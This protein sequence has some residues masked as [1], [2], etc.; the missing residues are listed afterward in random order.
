MF[1][2]K[3]GVQLHIESFAYGPYPCPQKA[4][5][6]ARSTLPGGESTGPLPGASGSSLAP[7]VHSGPATAVNMEAELIPDADPAA[8][9]VRSLYRHKSCFYLLIYFSRWKW[10][11]WRQVSRGWRGCPAWEVRSTALSWA[12]LNG[13]LLGQRFLTLVFPTALLA[14][15]RGQ[16]SV[17]VF[18]RILWAMY[19]TNNSLM[20]NAG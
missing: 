5:G 8:L 9:S 16:L 15:P 6:S 19:K 14:K 13:P 20:R 1:K 2:G 11:W 10:C 7:T 3:V 17:S 12:K 18:V 4:P